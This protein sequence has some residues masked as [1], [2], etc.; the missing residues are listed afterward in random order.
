MED[1]NE[2]DGARVD[3]VRVITQEDDLRERYEHLFGPLPDVSDTTRFPAGARPGTSMWDA[4]T[5][6]DQHCV[7]RAFVNLGKSIAAFERTFTVGRSPFDQFAKALREG[8]STEGI[9]TPQAMRGLHLFIGEAGCRNCHS[10]PLFTDRAFHN[11][12]LPTNDGLFPTDAG[13]AG[14]LEFAHAAE[15]RLSSEWSDD[16]TGD[17]ARRAGNATAGPEHWGAMRTPTLRNLPTTGPY[18]HDGRFKTLAQ[19][20]AFYN[21]LDGQIRIDHHQ[22]TVLKP[23]LLPPEDLLALEAFLNSLQDGLLQPGSR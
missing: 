1:P 22:E 23:L 20:L 15:F 14:G 6:A 16:P 9:L 17:A 2:M 13:R 8:H 12:G 21:T 3:I 10:G 11:N 5:A 18:M 4:M 19:V 7:T